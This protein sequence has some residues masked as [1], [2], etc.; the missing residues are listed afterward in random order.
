LTRNPS[1]QRRLSFATLLVGRT[2]PV[3]A[4][5][6]IG[7]ATLSGINY[8]ATLRFCAEIHA[9][10]GREIIRRLGATVEH[11]DQRKRLSIVTA[12]D[13]KLVRAA[14]G[15]IAEEAINESRTIWHSI[16]CRWWGAGGYAP[17][18]ELGGIVCAI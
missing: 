2:K 15:S 16:A 8:E 18:S 13:E 5:R 17:Q 11:D 12:W 1:D 6:L 3:P 4:F 14:S 9:R 10:P 7:F